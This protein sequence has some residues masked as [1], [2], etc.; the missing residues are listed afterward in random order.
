[1]SWGIQKLS[2][3][4]VETE[5]TPAEVSELTYHPVAFDDNGQPVAPSIL[6]AAPESLFGPDGAAFV[7]P[8]DS[9]RLHIPFGPVRVTAPARVVYVIDEPQRKGFAYGTLPGHPEQGEEAFIIE[10]HDDGSVWICIRAFSRPA[11]R[12]MWPAYPV[13]RLAQEFYTRRYER[14]LAGVIPDQNPALNE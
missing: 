12:W 9:A 10:Q 2:G 13:M 8:G 1:M 11:H 4:T 3:M 5:S 14:S 6:G 7:V